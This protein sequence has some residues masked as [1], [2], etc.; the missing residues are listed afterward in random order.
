VRAMNQI[1]VLLLRLLPH[2]RLL[3]LKKS[4]ACI[5]R[6][7]IRPRHCVSSHLTFV[8]QINVATQFAL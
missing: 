3:S 1:R 7:V 8:V 6:L 4:V 5:Q 2:T